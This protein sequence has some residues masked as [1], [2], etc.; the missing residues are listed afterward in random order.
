MTLAMVAGDAMAQSIFKVSVNSDIVRRMRIE[1]TS[2][3]EAF[4]PGRW[5]MEFWLIAEDEPN[6]SPGSPQIPASTFEISAVMP[7]HLINPWDGD[8]NLEADRDARSQEFYVMYVTVD[9]ERRRVMILQPAQSSFNSF[10]GSFSTKGYLADY[11][12]GDTIEQD[13]WG[14]QLMTGKVTVE[15]VEENLAGPTNNCGTPPCPLFE[16]TFESNN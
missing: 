7:T 8:P 2:P 4:Q 10:T 9:G 12:G 13:L 5:H 11:A 16:G 15:V 3:D 6:T 1:S 14:V